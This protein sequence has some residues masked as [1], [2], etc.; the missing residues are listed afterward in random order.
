ML[1]CTKDCLDTVEV[2]VG[3]GAS[4]KLR[5]KDGW[6]SFHIACREGHGNIVH[7]LLQADL[8][9]SNWNTTSKN[10][11]TPLHTVGEVYYCNIMNI[12]QVQGFF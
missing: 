1:A 7:F 6:N 11:R 2:L 4:L 10:G 9:P 12:M 3:Y 5:N 8:D